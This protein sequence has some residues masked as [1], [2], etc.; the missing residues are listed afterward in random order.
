MVRLK[1]GTCY[2]SF[3]HFE[4]SIPNGSIKIIFAPNF[5][6]FS[7]VSIPNGSIKIIIDAVTWGEF[8]VSIP[9]GSIKICAA[10]FLNYI[11]KS[12]QFQMVRL[13]CIYATAGNIL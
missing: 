7:E 13:K 11:K 8:N 4:V 5:G 9:N 10:F 6:N 12:F 2:K 3:C 1:S